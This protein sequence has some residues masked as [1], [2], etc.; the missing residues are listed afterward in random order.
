MTNRPRITR[1]K[2]A[3]GNV[4]RHDNN[5][6]ND[7]LFLDLQFIRLPLSSSFLVDHEPN[8]EVFDNTNEKDSIG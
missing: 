5:N 6:N 2:A 4:Y 7:N 1:L 8:S 3:V